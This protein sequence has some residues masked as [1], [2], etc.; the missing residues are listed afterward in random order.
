MLFKRSLSL[1]VI[2]IFIVGLAAC[3]QAAAPSPA[4]PEV[5][6]AEPAAEETHAI[7]WSYE[8]EGGPEHWSNLEN[9]EDPEVTYKA[10]GNG[11]EQSPI[12]LTDAAMS[13][14]ENISFAYSDSEVKILNNG[15]TIQVNYDEGSSIEIDGTVYTLKQF[16][17][18]SPSEHAAD[19][20]LYP[21]EMH[22]VHADANKNL[23][24]VGVFITEGAENPAFAPVW[25][26]LPAEETKAIATGMR[27]NATD[28]LPTEQLVYRYHGS[29]TTPPCSE[30][31][32]WSVMKIPI[33]MS[34]EQI[35]MFTAIFEGNNRPLQPLNDRDLQLDETS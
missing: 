26:N 18:H 14:L 35:G 20:T 33:E 1:L 17:F 2:L 15:H 16:H 5:A 9:L 22:L 4:R 6:E 24:V 19:G 3:T 25:D 21:A 10:C 12:N 23:A 27:V 29:L 7:H 11:T 32:L 31:V 30:G 8:G 13:D 34:A 28:L